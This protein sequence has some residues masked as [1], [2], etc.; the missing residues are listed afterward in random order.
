MEQAARTNKDLIRALET[1]GNKLRI[2]SVVATSEAGSGHPTSCM[3][4]A[5]LTAAVFFHGMRYE[6]NDPKNPLNDRIVFSKGH[7]APLLYAAWAEA[8]AFP[9]EHLKTLRLIDSDLEGHPTPRLKWVEVAT[10]SLGQGLSC[11]VGMAL[12]S[13]FL[14]HVDNRIFVLMGDG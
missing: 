13:R 14:D 4:A 8:G 9:V 6:V 2:H 10:G 11:A 7:A 1:M 3:S 12:N 5:D